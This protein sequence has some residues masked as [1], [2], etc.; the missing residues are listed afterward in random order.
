MNNASDLIEKKV[1]II[2][3]GNYRCY[4]PERYC[5]IIINVTERTKTYIVRLVANNSRFGDGRFERMFA[6]SP[7]VIIKKDCSAHAIL[8]W[9]DDMFTIYP[10]RDGIPYLFEKIDEKEDEK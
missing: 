2:L 6:K 10:Y 7:K 3:N 1:I 8:D 9:K 4:N 5:D